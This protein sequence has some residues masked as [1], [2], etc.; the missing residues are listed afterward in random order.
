MIKITD[1]HRKNSQNILYKI[2]KI[3]LKTYFA[4]K[5][6]KKMRKNIFATILVAICFLFAPSVVSAESMVE[7]N[8][9]NFPDSIFREYVKTLDTSDDGKLSDAEIAAVTEIDVSDESIKSLEGIEVFTSLQKLDCSRCEVTSLDV[10]G[11][12]NLKELNCSVN[13][14]HALYN[15]GE[16]PLE[17]TLGSLDVAGCTGLETLYCSSGKLTGLDIDTCTNLKQLNCSNNELTVLNVSSNSNLAELNCSVNDLASLDVSG[18]VQLKELSCQ[19]MDTLTSLKV[20]GCSALGAL[21]CR[22]TD[23][24]SL[25]VSGCSELYA[26]NCSKTKITNLDVSNNPKLISL[27]CQGTLLTSVGLNDSLLNAY[28]KATKQ[29]DSGENRDVYILDEPYVFLSVPKDCGVYLTLSEATFPDEK[30]RDIVKSKFNNDSEENKLSGNELNSLIE[31]T[32]LNLESKGIVDLTGIKN[33]V[34]LEYLNCMVNDL[35]SLDV[36]DMTSLTLLQCTANKLTSLDISGCTNLDQLFCQKNELEGLNVSDNENLKE[37]NCGENKLEEFDANQLK[38]LETLRIYDNVDLSSLKIEEC[39]ALGALDCMNTAITELDVKKFPELYSLRCNNTKIIY[40]DLSGNPKME[41]LFIE[42]SPIKTVELNDNLTQAVVSG[43]RSDNKVENTD[44]Y[45]YYSGSDQFM[46]VVTHEFKFL[47]NVSVSGYI[48]NGTV[49][50]DKME[51]V[52]GGELVNITAVPNDGYELKEI[53]VF[54]KNGTVYSS[55]DTET[56]AFTMPYKN[57]TVNAVFQSMEGVANT[58]KTESGDPKVEPDEPKTESDEPDTGDL[59]SF[60]SWI[61]VMIISGVMVFLLIRKRV[62]NK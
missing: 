24:S 45:S 48:T 34:A 54:D 14:D 18:K 20:S 41:V 10:S 59:G 21:H 2:I 55:L 11:M 40:L 56:G 29:Y 30:F 31:C 1:F 19:Q 61:W 3:E 6:D 26:L 27:T 50:V 38:K 16:G 23:I 52:K 35:T 46:L 51:N 49:T 9:A 7:I 28:A 8:E 17:Y 53:V 47:Y 57:V 12:S 25:D 58:S 4:E 43:E 32:D 22:D 39:S 37:I 62:Y 5:G 15:N 33:F 60:N 44:T 13:Y 36:S 42:G